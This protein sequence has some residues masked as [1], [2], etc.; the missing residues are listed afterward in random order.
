MDL[1]IDDLEEDEDD[2]E[3][4]E[5]KQL[6]DD[7][8]DSKMMPIISGGKVGAKRFCARYNFVPLSPSYQ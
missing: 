5:E 7:F 3:E 6:R 4:Q 2:Y 1:E 8:R